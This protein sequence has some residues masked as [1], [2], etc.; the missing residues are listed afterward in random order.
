MV[1]T[2][3][4]LCNFGVRYKLYCVPSFVPTPHISSHLLS[5]QLLLYRQEAEAYINIYINIYIY[6]MKIYIINIFVLS[7]S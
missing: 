7:K 5:S 3:G 4:W 2:G 6:I 1:L